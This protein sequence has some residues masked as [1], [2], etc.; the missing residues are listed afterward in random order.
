MFAVIVGINTVVELALA[1][2]VRLSDQG[3]YSL[4]EKV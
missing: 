4:L 1:S 2:K 3:R